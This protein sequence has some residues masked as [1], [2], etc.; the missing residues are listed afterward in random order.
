MKRQNCIYTDLVDFYGDYTDWIWR[1]LTIGGYICREL[2]FERGTT[3]LGS[4]AVR[5]LRFYKA[6][7]P[8]ESN[9]KGAFEVGLEKGYKRVTD[10]GSDSNRDEANLVCDAGCLARN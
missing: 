1:C 8:L 6:A 9:T 10:S 3:P 2:F 4:G 7:T 5:G